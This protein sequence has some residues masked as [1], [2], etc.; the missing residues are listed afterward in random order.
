MWFLL[1][2]ITTCFA[3]CGTGCL[4]CFNSSQNSEEICIKC[5]DNFRQTS[6]CTECQLFNPYENFSDTNPLILMYNKSCIVTN[7]TDSVLYWK[8]LFIEELFFNTPITFNVTKTMTPMLGICHDDDTNNQYRFGKYFHFYFPPSSTKNYI[9]IYVQKNTT[10]GKVKIE[11]TKTVFDDANRVYEPEC[12]STTTLAGQTGY[13]ITRTKSTETNFTL[14]VGMVEAFDCEMTVSMLTADKMLQNIQF[15]VYNISNFVEQPIHLHLDFSLMSVTDFAACSPQ[16]TPYKSFFFQILG[17]IPK[18]SRIL[19]TSSNGETQFLEY[20]KCVNVTNVYAKCYCVNGTRMRRDLW[21]MHPETGFVYSPVG[22]SFEENIFRLFSRNMVMRT[23]FTMRVI[24]PNNCNEENNGGNCS[25][26]LGKCVC[27]SE[28][29]GGE[30]CHE[31]CYY[32]NTWH[33]QNINEKC[34]YGESNCDS[35][36]N[37]YNG[38]Y[39]LDHYCVSE[40]CYNNIIQENGDLCER[41]KNHCQ[42]NC[43][44]ENGYILKSTKCIPITCGNG[45][46]DHE[47]EQCDSGASCNVIDCTCYEGFEPDK[48]RPGSCTRK[49]HIVLITLVTI[50]CIFLFFVLIIT[51]CLTIIISRKERFILKNV[52]ETTEYPQ[53][54]YYYDVSKMTHVMPYTNKYPSNKCNLTFGAKNKTLKIDETVY[55]V[56]EITN[57]TTHP[58]FIIFHSPNVSKY[59]VHFCPQT[60][61]IS[62]GKTKQFV[63]LF[64]PHCTTQLGGT[65]FYASMYY[66]DKAKLIEL[67]KL[68]FDKNVLD[69]GD[70]LQY[71]DLLSKLNPSY[72]ELMVNTQIENSFRVDYDEV[73]L[74]PQKLNTKH[75]Q[76][77]KTI[78]VYRGTPVVLKS[79]DLS[80]LTSKGAEDLKIS[81]DKYYSAIKNLRSPYLLMPN[82]Y[83][84]YE[85][86]IFSMYEVRSLGSADAYFFNPIYKGQFSYLYKLKVMKD[87]ECGLHYLHEFKLLHLNLKLSNVLMNTFSL[88]FPVVTAQICHFWGRA[89]LRA[90]AED[91]GVFMKNP[92]CDPPEVYTHIF[93]NFSDVF[94]FGILCWEIFYEKRTFED[95]KTLFDIKSAVI[96]GKMPPLDDR[97]PKDLGNLISRCW[98][99]NYLQ[100]ISFKE[101]HDILTKIFEEKIA[102]NTENL[103]KDTTNN[104]FLEDVKID[105]FDFFKKATK[106]RLL[107]PFSIEGV[108][109]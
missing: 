4:G 84:L 78:A 45:K 14:F 21:K 94:S 34:Y 60:R 12:F 25:I 89:D 26:Q 40:A 61:I 74:S 6:L 68:I 20:V 7:S 51:V 97:I 53:P 56:I 49:Y 59:S 24:C 92:R 47:E 35:Y 29:Y 102:V 57:H 54:T 73:F 90:K 67:Q 28:K 101:V 58:M 37:C 8:P 9:N 86:Q 69:I 99:Y 27:T 13:S 41:G 63:L 81:S 85:Q 72:F 109:V 105:K 46:L 91:N 32:N 42:S 80:T 88:E 83:F 33:I 70:S 87:I 30:D 19:M 48:K 5:K 106:Q 43:N 17:S 96:A 79:I 2:L 100:R 18:K 31:L 64:T 77:I 108:F 36:C 95:S 104:E 16:T 23:E 1:Q 66:G 75:S 50:S 103:L 65:Y 15:E 98:E 62:R 39:I 71:N 3:Y 44:C 22:T 38:T 52:A 107:K 93:G 10:E 76:K 82:G 11:L 55:E